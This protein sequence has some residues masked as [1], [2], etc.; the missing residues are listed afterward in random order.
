MRRRPGG[1]Y[2]GDRF[3]PQLRGDVQPVRIVGLSLPPTRSWS[4]MPGRP[5]LVVAGA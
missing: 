5:V 2:T 4:G 3:F 1:F